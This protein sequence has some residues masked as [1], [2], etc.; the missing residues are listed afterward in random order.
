MLPGIEKILAYIGVFILSI[1]P[2][3]VC[4]VALLILLKLGIKFATRPRSPFL[5]LLF[6]IIPASA[7]FFFWAGLVSSAGLCIG[8][9]FKVFLSISFAPPI[10]AVLCFMLGGLWSLDGIVT[11]WGHCYMDEH[12]Y[13]PVLDLDGG[14]YP[15]DACTRCR[16]HAPD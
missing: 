1:S 3:M 12:N 13:A 8:E 10:C 5:W 11:K 16:K 14:N 4:G 7:D 2:L 6:Q 15:Y 9:T